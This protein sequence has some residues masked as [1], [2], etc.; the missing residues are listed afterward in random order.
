MFEKITA[1]C[2]DPWICSGI[3][4]ALLQVTWL[5]C[6]IVGILPGTDGVYIAPAF[7]IGLFA[8]LLI[9]VVAHYGERNSGFP[10]WIEN[11][12]K[13]CAGYCITLLAICLCAMLSVLW[14]AK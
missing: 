3:F 9:A 7:T 6:V 11:I 13:L 8:T 10:R 5:Y 4:C 1:V 14:I 2:K 12:G